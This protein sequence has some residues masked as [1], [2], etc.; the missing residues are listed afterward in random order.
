MSTLGFLP[1]TISK[2]TPT[3]KPH[4][5]EEMVFRALVAYIAPTVEGDIELANETDK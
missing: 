5:K 1:T 2:S 3:Q 4:K